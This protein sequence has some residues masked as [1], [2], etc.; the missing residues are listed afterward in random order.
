MRVR[1]YDCIDPLDSASLRYNPSFS[2]TFQIAHISRARKHWYRQLTYS[3][4]PIAKTSLAYEPAN[5]QGL[6]PHQHSTYVLIPVT[7]KYCGKLFMIMNH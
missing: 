6:L 5:V 4:T 7:K 2:Q 1:Q 3:H